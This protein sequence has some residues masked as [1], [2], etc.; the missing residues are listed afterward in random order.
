MSNVLVLQ[1]HDLNA[2]D[3]SALADLDL[4]APAAGQGGSLRFAVAEDF[5][6]PEQAAAALLH[7]E[8]DFAILPDMAFGDLGLIVSDMDSTL[9]TIECVDEIAAGVG[10]KEQV[11]EITERSMRGELDFEQSLRER[12]ALLAG[13]NES[14][15]QQV[16]DEV[17]KL[18]PGAEFLLKE[19]RKHGVKFMLVSGGFTFFTQRLQQRL[20]FEYQ[21]ANV[22]EAEGGKLTGRLN[23]RIIDAKAKAD[24]LVQHRESLGLQAQQVLAMGDG[25]NDIPM[26]QEAGIGVA[27]RAKP[28][29]QQHA[30]A[31]VRFG[32]LERI[33]G[34]FA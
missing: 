16:Y 3:L 4:A 32:G 9:I 34:W 2:C 25:A 6:L 8:I 29:A 7:Q 14:V 19:C 1:H 15:L 22:L 5:V 26:L 31:C 30:D 28:K 18:S 17:L 11:A 13:L 24:L 33:R 27:Y 20:G 23:G 12:V 21:Y 10:L